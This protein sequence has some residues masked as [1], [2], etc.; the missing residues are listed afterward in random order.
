MFNTDDNYRY[1]LAKY[2]EYLSPVSDLFA[3]CLLGNHFHC[4][5]R[6]RGLEELAAFQKLSKSQ[7]ASDSVKLLMIL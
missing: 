6:I 7:S 1:F 5:I 3:Y 2:D 4:L